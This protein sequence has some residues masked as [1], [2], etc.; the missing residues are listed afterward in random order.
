MLVLGSGLFLGPGGWESISVPWPF[1]AWRSRKSSGD[2]SRG[3]FVS[4]HSLAQHSSFSTLSGLVLSRSIRPLTVSNSFLTA[5]SRWS[6][7]H[8]IR[9]TFHAT[10]SGRTYHS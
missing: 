9:V 4:S 6:Q 3:S 2:G 5:M 8:G 7:L 10:K 1:L